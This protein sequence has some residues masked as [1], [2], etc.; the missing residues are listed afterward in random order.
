MH[1]IKKIL[2]IKLVCIEKKHNLDGVFTE[3]TVFSDTVVVAHNG[4]IL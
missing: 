3:E 4:S 2:Q 1:Y